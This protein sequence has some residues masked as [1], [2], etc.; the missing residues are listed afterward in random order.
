M[1]MPFSDLRRLDLR[2]FFEMLDRFE[3]AQNPPGQKL[4]LKNLRNSAEVVLLERLFVWTFDRRYRHGFKLPP[5]S[6][7]DRQDQGI[8]YA[9]AWRI[10]EMLQ[11]DLCSGEY[12]FDVGEK[13][14]HYLLKHAPAS[15]RCWIYRSFAGQFPGFV[16]AEYVRRSFPGL[17]SD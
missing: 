6:D 8:E 1:S 17:L 13:Q 15:M 4:I 3:H 14:L 5:L 11:E 16:T 7:F 10:L 12:C 9:M 2:W